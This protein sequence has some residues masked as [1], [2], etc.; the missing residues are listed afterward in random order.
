MKGFNECS[1]Y[2]PVFSSRYGCWIVFTVG[3]LLWWIFMRICTLRTYLKVNFS[4][5]LSSVLQVP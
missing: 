3:S 4:S 5:A 2:S 1:R